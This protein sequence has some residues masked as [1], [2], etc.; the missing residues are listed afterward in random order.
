MKR[1]FL[2]SPILLAVS[3][4]LFGIFWIVLTD[5]LLA[6]R[7]VDAN[8]LSNWQTLKGWVFVFG[9]TLLL[10]YLLHVSARVHRATQQVLQKQER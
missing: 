2:T 10:Y 6:A 9:S 4:L 7:I 8:T 5:Q 1:F 3:Y